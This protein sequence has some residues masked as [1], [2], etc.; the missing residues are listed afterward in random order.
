MEGCLVA[1]VSLAGF[2]IILMTAAGAM[3][4]AV[5]PDGGGDTGTVIRPAPAPFTHK[6]RLAVIFANFATR[7]PKGLY[8]S[9][10]ATPLGGPDSFLGE[11]FMAAAFVPGT[12]ATVQEIEFAG[13][14]TGGASNL[15]RVHLYADAAGLPGQELWARNVALP[16]LAGCCAVVALADKSATPVMAGVQYWI[17]VTA[18]ADTTAAWNFNVL[19]QVDPALMAV[20]RGMG[21]EASSSAPALA[22]GIYGQ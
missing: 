3:A 11:Q 7:Y 16:A 18:R 6:G 4:A 13:G 17:G 9:V 14:F 10:Q 22:F 15:V 12:D 8:S 21:W 5:V 2:A 20:D 1:K 19:D